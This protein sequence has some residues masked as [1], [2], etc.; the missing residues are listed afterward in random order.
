MGLQ[1]RAKYALYGINICIYGMLAV[2]YNRMQ[3][4]LE[5]VITGRN[6][7]GIIGLLL[8]VGPLVSIFA[9]I[10]WGYVADRSKSKNAVL[11]LTVALSSLAF[12]LLMLDHSP[13]YLAVIL[14]LFMFF[15]SSFQGIVD[16]ITLEYTSQTNMNYGLVRVTGSLAYGVVS[17][18]LSALTANGY[19]PMFWT[20][21][22]IAA[23]AVVSLFAAPKVAGHGV[24]EGQTRS[25][26]S[27]GALFRDRRLMLLI[28]FVGVV[29]FAW[30]YYTNFFPSHLTNT[31]GR[32]DYIWGLN[33][34]LTVLGE[35]PFFLAFRFLFDKI[36]IRRLMLYSFAL[37]VLRYAG[38]AFLTSTPALL[39]LAFVTG[40][41][42]TVFTYC[43]SVYINQ[44]VAPENKASANSLMYAL[45]N[46]IPRVLSAALGGIMT[47]YLGYV[48][49]TVLCTVLCGAAILLFWLGFYRDKTVS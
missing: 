24:A 35:V 13:I 19:T 41:A 37:S 4:Y 49:S 31:L 11:A 16:I 43:T 12:F 32:P 9:P 36:G 25:K 29:Q 20:Y 5:S 30:S 40:F 39:A 2:Y 8:A 48:F 21:F 45:G 17:F 23:A 14:A 44:C 15:M 26:T 10:L 38:L 28:L 3:K 33:A 7:T 34:F 46:G 1:K 27:I 47:Q 42:V 22:G 18:S 6:H